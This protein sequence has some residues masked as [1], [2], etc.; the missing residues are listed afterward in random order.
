MVC[1]ME[2]L[3]NLWVFSV[4]QQVWLWIFRL[5]D[6]CIKKCRFVISDMVS[7]FII[8]IS[9]RVLMS[10]VLCLEILKWKCF[11]GVFLQLGLG[12]LD[13]FIVGWLVEVELCVVGWCFFVWDV[14]LVWIVS[15]Y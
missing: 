13:Y 15:L 14:L 6:C 12:I 1:L 9:N 4:Y 2:I 5:V 3:V 8:V 7:V 11:I 10:E